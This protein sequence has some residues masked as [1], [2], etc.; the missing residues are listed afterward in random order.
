MLPL[1]IKTA[2]LYWPSLIPL[3]MY[4]KIHDPILVRYT[5][6]IMRWG[7]GGRERDRQTEREGTRRGKKRRGEGGKEEHRR[8]QRTYDWMRRRRQARPH[9]MD[10]AVNQSWGKYFAFKVRFPGHWEMNM[11]C[12]KR[13]MSCLTHSHSNILKLFSFWWC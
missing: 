13:H 11:H 2:V 10:L 1:E 9:I 3:S 5:M 7:V 4:Y 8:R 6:L 12:V